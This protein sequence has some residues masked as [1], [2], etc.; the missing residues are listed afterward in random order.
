M[1]AT[2]TTNFGSAWSCVSDLTL[3]SVQVS[4]NQVVA[5]A[6]ARRLQTPRGG[7]I[8]DPNYGYDL[9][10][11]LNADVTPAQIASI[12]SSINAECTKDERVSSAASSVTFLSGALIVSVL[13]TTAA[14]PF[15][16]VLSVSS[17]APNAV[18]LLSV[19]P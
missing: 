13:L 2:V 19:F 18:T 1:S 16:L 4:G 5:E 9:T 3:P 15:T 11:W 17:L 14:G 8:D 7:L 12:Q 10:A 6:I